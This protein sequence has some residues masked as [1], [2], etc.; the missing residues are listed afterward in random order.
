[1]EDEEIKKKNKDQGENPSLS[2]LTLTLTQE[3]PHP[4][5]SPLFVLNPTAPIPTGGKGVPPL[6]VGGGCPS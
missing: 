2:P 1:M 6:G 4:L 5:P 3:P